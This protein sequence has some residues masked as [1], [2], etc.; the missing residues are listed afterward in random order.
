ML[1]QPNAVSYTPSDWF[2]PGVFVQPIAKRTRSAVQPA[3]V[4]GQRL[5]RCIEVT[6]RAEVVVA[7]S[8]RRCSHG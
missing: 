7:F 5:P 1:K 2:S 8:E 6:E 4:A 3:V